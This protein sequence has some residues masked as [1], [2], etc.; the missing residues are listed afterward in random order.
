VDVYR[1]CDPSYYRQQVEREGRRSEDEYERHVARLLREIGDYR[2]LRPIGESLER[3]IAEQQLFSVEEEH[4]RSKERRRVIHE[5]LVRE[6]QE[7]MFAKT[8]ADALVNAKIGGTLL[9][10]AAVVRKLIFKI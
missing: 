2:D 5:E 7:Q 3:Q 6:R 8:R 10:A 1:P 4:R 9:V